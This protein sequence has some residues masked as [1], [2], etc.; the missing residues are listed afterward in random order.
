MERDS[1]KFAVMYGAIYQDLY[2]FAFCMTTN[3]HDAED[4]VSEAVVNAYEHM[5]DL[6]SEEA[7]K[8]WM[9][10]ILVNVCRK[11][12]R[13]QKKEKEKESLLFLEREE[14]AAQD[15]EQAVDIREAFAALSEEEKMIVGFSVFGGYQSSEIGKALGRKPSTVRSIRARALEKMRRVL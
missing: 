6:R 13:K 3:S 2:R 12:W 8:S 15:I 9:F 10:T 4:V 7:F 11:K 1:E 5:G 14:E